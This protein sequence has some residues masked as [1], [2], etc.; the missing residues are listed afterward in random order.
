MEDF[1][2]YLEYFKNLTQEEQKE[3]IIDELKMIS[4]LTNKMCTEIGANNKEIVNNEKDEIAMITH[5]C[6]IKNSLSDFS[7][8]LTEISNEL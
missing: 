3:I 2:K 4:N 6:S 7:N 8:K 5:I 1:N